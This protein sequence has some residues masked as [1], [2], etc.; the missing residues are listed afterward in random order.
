MTKLIVCCDGTW[1][2]A[3]DRT[4]IFRIAEAAKRLKMSFVRRSYSTCV[5][6]HKSEQNRSDNQSEIKV[7]YD[8]GLGTGFGSYFMGGVFGHGV[9][10]NIREAYRWLMANYQKGDEIFLFGFSRGAFTVRSLTGLMHYAGLIQPWDEALVEEAWNRYSCRTRSPKEKFADIASRTHHT[11]QNVPI[12][13]IGVFDTVGSLGIPI[14]FIRRLCVLLRLV[15]DNRFHDTKLSKSVQTARHALAIDE[16]RDPFRPALWERP[17]GLRAEDE[18]DVRQVWFAGVHSDI[19]GGYEDKRL[20][21]VPLSWMLQEAANAGLDLQSAFSEDRLFA[22]RYG[23]RHESMTPLYKLMHAKIIRQITDLSDHSRPI[24]DAHRRMSNHGSLLGKLVAKMRKWLRRAPVVP[25]VMVGEAVHRSVIQRMKIGDAD[26]LP[27]GTL[28][29]PYQPSNLPNDIDDKIWRL[30]EIEEERR[31]QRNAVQETGII[32]QHVD[33]RI[34]DQSTAGVQL[35]LVEEDQAIGEFI[36]LKA[37]IFEKEYRGEV[38]WR[39]GNRLGVLLLPE[40]RS[41]KAA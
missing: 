28:Q 13:F 35:I 1:N 30:V 25:P 18:I 20:A 14:N 31:E 27:E 3:D 2:D 4:H 34:I 22:N 10:Q 37:P 21:E 33:C 26:P 32:D 29:R 16:R 41:G 19:G 23:R 36:T 38:R 15:K 11:R 39:H 9:S 6:E 8:K 40:E 17:E 7:Y 24:G 12:R 5:T